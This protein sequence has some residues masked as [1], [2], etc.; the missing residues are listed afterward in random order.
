MGWNLQS[1]GSRSTDDGF[2]TPLVFGLF[3]LGTLVG[4]GMLWSL[5]APISGAVIAAG[6]LQ[7]ESNRKTIEHLEGGIVEAILVREGERV[8][9]GQPLIRLDDAT[10]RANLALFEASLDEMAARRARL[11]AELTDADQP[12][13]PAL[14]SR[15]SAAEDV[16]K[17][18]EGERALFETRREARL[19]ER[20][21]LD[22]RIEQ[23][24]SE[25]EAST[26]QRQ[27]AARQIELLEEELAGLRK[28]YDAG[29]ESRTR[30]RGLEREIARLAGE[31][32]A[33]AAAIARARSQIDGA[34]L[35]LLRA[36]KT[37][38]EEVLAEMRD[39]ESRTVELGERRVVLLA[40][41][42][43]REIKA[44]LAGVV[45]SLR[46]HTVGGVIMPGEPIMDI[47]PGDDRLIVSARIF[48]QDVDRVRPGAPARVRLPAFNQRTTPELSGAIKLVSGD[49]LLDEATGL[50]YY[51]IH[52]ELPRDLPGALK[53]DSL[54]PGMPAEVFIH[55]GE[56]SAMSYLLKP[57]TDSFAR[58]LKED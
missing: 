44:P 8:R 19:S 39:V 14:L 17:I 51:L 49:R 52:I 1:D 10:E 24:E 30:V 16:R 58:A 12:S 6:T 46:V 9:E 22:R 55:T 3:A 47:V 38:R 41:M 4:G 11:L 43:R 23:I 13:F 50:P 54:V 5:L 26:A 42:G 32:G 25:I 33:Q 21:L 15:G 36:E 27:S 18:V 45:L 34:R 53:M 48:P 31:R 29:Y 37:L 57:L 40:Q 2:R 56:R 7:V 20:R 28:L 35:E